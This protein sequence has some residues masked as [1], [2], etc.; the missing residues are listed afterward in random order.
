[1][2]DDE[3]T[4]RMLGHSDV[5]QDDPRRDPQEQLLLRLDLS[6]QPVFDIGE[7]RLYFFI[8]TDDLAA[9][10]LDRAP[11]RSAGDRQRGSVPA[12]VRCRESR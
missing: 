8:A 10:R 11:R 3:P 12:D 5:V 7:G 1:M 4:H 6:Q 2:S 9:G